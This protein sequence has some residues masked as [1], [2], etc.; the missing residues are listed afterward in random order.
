MK[1]KI[2]S[3]I[4]ST[5]PV[6]RV[7]ETTARTGPV[8]RAPAAG[9][10]SDSVEITSLSA[11]LNQ[12]EGVLS[13]VPVVDS[14]QVNAIKEAIRDGRFQVNSEVVADRLLSSVKELLLQRG[15]A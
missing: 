14:A 1:M 11:R 12:L 8:A 7:N 6:N 3:G 4:P 15:S 13:G 2:D 9:G 5:S 10:A